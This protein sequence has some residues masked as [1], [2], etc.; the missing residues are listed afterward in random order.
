MN[1]LK[2][3]FYGSTISEYLMKKEVQLS[4]LKNSI[5]NTLKFVF[6][7]FNW[8]SVEVVSFKTGSYK[9]WGRSRPRTSHKASANIQNMIIEDFVYWIRKSSSSRILSG[10]LCL[11]WLYHIRTTYVIFIHNETKPYSNTTLP[12][13]FGL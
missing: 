5:K 7:I 10:V 3:K 6:F 9:S 8:N 1:T 11:K 2:K 13:T 12:K 4:T